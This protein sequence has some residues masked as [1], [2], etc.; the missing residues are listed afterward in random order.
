MNKNLPQKYKKNIFNNF[1]RKLKALFLNQKVT[2]TQEKLKPQV[3][4]FEENKNLVNVNCDSVKELKHKKSIQDVENPQM[5][6]F[7]E[8]EDNTNLLN[9]LSKDKL[10]KILQYYLNQNNQ[11]KLLLKKSI[12]NFSFQ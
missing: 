7:T 9:S 8:I 5:E 4:N 3:D 2:K 12:H 6:F 10:T 11:K 1:F